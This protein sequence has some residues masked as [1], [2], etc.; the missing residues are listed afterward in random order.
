MTSL[1]HCECCFCSNCH[2]SSAEG[3]VVYPNRNHGKQQKTGPGLLSGSFSNPQCLAA[4]GNGQWA[5]GRCKKHWM[6]PSMCRP[7]G[8]RPWPWAMTS[9]KTLALGSETLS[10]EGLAALCTLLATKAANA[11]R[12]LPLWYLCLETRAASRPLRTG[13]QT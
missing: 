5:V 7:W 8:P 9:V 2:Q 10:P 6:L 4:M 1:P 11:S 12:Y 3:S 13:H